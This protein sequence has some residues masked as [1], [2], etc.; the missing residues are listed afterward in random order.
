MIAAELQSYL[1]AKFNIKLERGAKLDF[2]S[3][4]SVGVATSMAVEI[5]LIELN[6]YNFSHNAFFQLQKNPKKLVFYEQASMNN[7]WNFPCI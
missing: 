3:R 5:I 4:M 2:P 7:I 6:F 1:Y